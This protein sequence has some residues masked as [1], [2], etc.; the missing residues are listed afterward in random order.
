V[1]IAVAEA[2]LPEPQPAVQ[3]PQAVEEPSPYLPQR[4]CDPVA[5]PGLVA[6]RAL[7]FATYGRGRDGGMVRACSIGRLSEHK[8]GRAWDWMLAANKPADRAVADSVLR[9]L[10]G[11]GAVNAR[12]TGV[13]YVI[14]NGKIWSVYN[15]SAGWRTYKGANPHTDH[16]HF[17]FS[18]SGAMRRTSWWTGAVAPTDYGP[19]PLIAGQLAPRHTQPRYTPCPAAAPAPAPA[20]APSPVPKNGTVK[21]SPLAKH[22]NTIVR[23]GSR[24]SA[25]SALQAALRMPS[26][27][28]TG[29]F[30]GITHGNVVR[31]QKAHRLRATGVVGR[32]TWKALS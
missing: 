29:Y 11:N 17:S 18:W 30:G 4:S 26:R 3:L 6:F 14:W 16:I 19:C 8:E 2:A 1:P 15:Q 5:R 25:V 22:Y 21:V 23:K 13:M 31:F 28:R 12:R 27:Y 32:P 10:T 7:M 9:W 24:G 20:P